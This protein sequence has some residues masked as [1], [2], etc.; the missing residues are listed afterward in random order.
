MEKYKHIF[1]RIFT[2]LKENLHPELTYH[3]VEHTL[4]VMEWAK[5]LSRKEGVGEREFILIQIAALFHDSGFLVSRE[6]HEKRGC[7]IARKELADEDFSHEE[8]EAICGMIMATRVPQK[9]TN[10][11]ERILVDADLYYLGTE[12]YSKYAT[13]LRDELRSFNPELSAEDWKNIQIKF[14][15]HHRYNTDFAKT[16]L[17]PAKLKQLEVIKQS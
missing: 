14:L 3:N 13:Q 1:D 9:P 8:I 10:Q 12:K 4:M 16:Y 17:E 15:Q 6:E 7:E 11:L 2:R 5:E